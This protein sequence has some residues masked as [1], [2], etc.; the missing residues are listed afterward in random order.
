MDIGSGSG[1]IAIALAMHIPN[2]EILAL[3]KSADAI[4]V[5]KRNILFHNLGKRVRILQS[6]VRDYVPDTSFDIIVSNPP[7]IAESEMP[8]VSKN[9]SHYEPYMALSDNADG[10]EFYRFFAELFPDWLQSAGF[11]LLEFGGNAQSPAMQEIFS[12]FE[13]DI[14]K[15]YQGDDR[16]ILIRN[17]KATE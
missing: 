5:L 9:V 13:T 8:G 12:E 6:D 10:L 7:Y 2:A 3:E 1:C 11:A 14:I 17:K 16:V 15:D 4:D